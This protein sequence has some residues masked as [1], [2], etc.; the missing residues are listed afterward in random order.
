MHRLQAHEAFRRR[1]HDGKG[2]NIAATGPYDPSV[3]DGVL[4]GSQHDDCP[5]VEGNTV[6]DD[7]ADVSLDGEVVENDDVFARHVARRQGFK[8]SGLGHLGDGE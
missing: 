7:G 4:L 6:A 5:D 2:E 3:K 8:G 1:G